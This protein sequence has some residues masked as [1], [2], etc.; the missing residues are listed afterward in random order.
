MTESAQRFTFARTDRSPLGQ[1]WWTIDRW[2][3]GATLVLVTLGILLSFG[4][5]PAAASRMHVTDPFHF[6]IR[7]TVFGLASAGLMIIVSMLTPRLIRRTAFF[8]FIA[9]I[10]VMFAL[11]FVGHE[12]KGATRWLEFGGFTLQPSEF[13]KPALIVLAAWMFAEGQKGQGVP[14]VSI[15]FAMYALAVVLL[16]RQPDVGQTVLITMAFGAC[17]FMAGVP[18]RWFLGLAAAAGVGGISL[19]F[20][21]DHVAARLA[22]ERGDQADAAGIMLV[23]RIVHAM[24]LQMG[25]VRRPFLQKLL[26]L[27]DLALLGLIGHALSSPYDADAMAGAVRASTLAARSSSTSSAGPRACGRAS[28]FWSRPYAP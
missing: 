3:L 16:L 21:L 15:A 8:T 6:A 20:T 2:L 19:Y 1:W 5:S 10:A 14:G 4:N 22:V 9:A 18:I 7:Q 23:G 12:A 13:M 27:I 28:S 26:A 24:F 25:G 11:I 17:F